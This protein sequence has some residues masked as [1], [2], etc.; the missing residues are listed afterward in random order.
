[1]TKSLE[2]HAWIE[3]PDYW[4]DQDAK[5]ERTESHVN[6]FLASGQS[7]FDA[8]STWPDRYFELGGKI[9]HLIA[10]GTSLLPQPSGLIYIEDELRDALDEYKTVIREHVREIVKEEMERA[11]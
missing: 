1:M 3:H 5:W 10:E 8:I 6:D 7:E 11:A 2:P 9:A 4:E